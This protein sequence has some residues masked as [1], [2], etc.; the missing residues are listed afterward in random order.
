MN[1]SLGLMAHEK[2]YGPDGFITITL[3]GLVQ[4]NDRLALR[5]LSRQLLVS[6]NQSSTHDPLLED[7]DEEELIGAGQFTTYANTLKHL[8]ALLEPMDDSRK[9]VTKAL[10]IVLEEFDKFAE[11]NRQAFLYTLLDIVQGSKRRGGICVIG[12]T[13]VVVSFFISH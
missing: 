1:R 2:M 9:D 4:I 3:N 10:V 8:L 13:A 5:E 7:Q 12:T 11:L 6:L